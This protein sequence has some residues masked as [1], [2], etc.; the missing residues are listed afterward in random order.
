MKQSVIF[1]FI[2]EDWDECIS[3]GNSMYMKKRMETAR[4]I[5]EMVG[6]KQTDEQWYRLTEMVQEDL[7][8]ALRK[9]LD[10]NILYVERPN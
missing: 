6:I 7:Y 3:I 2:N 9:F 10:N 8:L 5:I 4:Q 1:T